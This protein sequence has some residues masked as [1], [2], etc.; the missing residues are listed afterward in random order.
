MLLEKYPTRERCLLERFK[1]SSLKRTSI[2]HYWDTI[3]KTEEVDG[4]WSTNLKLFICLQF[5][6]WKLKEIEENLNQN[7]SK[8]ILSKTFSIL[9]GQDK[10]VWKHDHQGKFSISSAYHILSKETFELWP[11]KLSFKLIIFIWKICSNYLFVRAKLHKRMQGIFPCCPICHNAE[12][13]LEHLFVLCLFAKVIWFGIDFSIR[14]DGL[15][16]TNIKD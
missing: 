4:K 5:H 6:T 13:S 9:G 14:I 10:F 8:R 3:K 7:L 1:H 2:L 11:F 15:A 12:E 16:L